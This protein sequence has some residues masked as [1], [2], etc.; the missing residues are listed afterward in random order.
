MY[1][2]RDVALDKDLVSVANS[3]AFVSLSD[4]KSFLDVTGTASDTLLTSM[5]NAACQ[6]IEA[7]C[8]ALLATRTVTETIYLQDDDTANLVLSHAPVI[9]LTSVAIDDVAQ[10]TGDYFVGKA[11]GFLRR[12]DGAYIAGTKIIVVYTT[13]FAAIP[14]P[15]VEATK[16]YVRDIFKGRTRVSGIKQEALTDV[17]SVAYSDSVA[18]SE[19][20]PG[21]VRLPLNVAALVGPYARRFF[22]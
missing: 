10:S 5:L 13:G 6:N 11:A 3:N 2:L 1:G 16:E 22:A 4:V 14:E 20:G 7:W 9:A 15:I 19:A 18:E 17:G 8:A 12:V 21:G